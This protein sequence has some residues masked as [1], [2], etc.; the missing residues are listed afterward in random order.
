MDIYML[1]RDLGITAGIVGYAQ[2]EHMDQMAAE[3]R[4]L[5]LEKKKFLITQFELLNQE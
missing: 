4:K 5:F 2:H 3:E 1:L